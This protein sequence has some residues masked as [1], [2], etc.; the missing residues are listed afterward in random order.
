MR[1]PEVKAAILSEENLP[2]D[3]HR[4]YESIADNTAY[5]FGNIFP[6]GDPPDYE[7]TPDRS[8]AGIAATTGRDPWEVLYDHLASGELLLAAFTNYA[9]GSEDHLAEMI[10]HPDTIIGL[11]DA[12]AHVRFICDAS[13][14]TYLLT[15]WVRD[16][17]RG[18][19]LP[20]ETVVQK[21][22]SGT[23]AAVG[24][25]DRGTLE[26]GKKADVNVID[27]EHL[28]LAPPRSVADLPA[29]GRRILQDA[30][31]RN[32]ELGWRG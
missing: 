16:R 13:A 1:K 30:Y 24:L 7:P 23:A 21:Q 19:R 8:I 18:A 17:S 5:M 22:T 20:I 15:H 29:G 4:Q 27:L 12:G 25:T 11:S 32:T 31:L 26:P 2:A 10:S 3:P 6:L 14:P 28:A 9:Q